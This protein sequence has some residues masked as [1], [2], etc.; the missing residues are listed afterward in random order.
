MTS[1]ELGIMPTS[2]GR[3][4]VNDAHHR[5]DGST[6]QVDQVTKEL[7]RNELGHVGL[8][9]TLQRPLDPFSTN[10]AVGLLVQRRRTMTNAGH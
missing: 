7:K 8:L 6:S 10:R 2:A 1:T 9:T 4:F 3:V 5:L